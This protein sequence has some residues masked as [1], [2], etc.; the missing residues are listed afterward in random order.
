ML[1]PSVASLGMTLQALDPEAIVNVMVVLNIAAACP[2][3][4]GVN[5]VMGYPKS[6]RFSRIRRKGKDAAGARASSIALVSGSISLR[7]G[8]CFSTSQTKAARRAIGE[9]FCGVLACPPF[10]LAVNLTLA[11]PFSETP[12]MAKFPLIPIMGSV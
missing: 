7:K 1:A 4:M 8:Q 10:P 11:R 6:H 12:I 5:H 3:I 9:F 2:L